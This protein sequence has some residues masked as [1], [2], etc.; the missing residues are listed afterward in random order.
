MLSDPSRDYNGSGSANECGAILIAKIS[1][2][3]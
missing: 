1:K 2:K 3:I